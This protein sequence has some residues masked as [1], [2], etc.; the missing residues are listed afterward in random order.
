MPP[1]S[2]CWCRHHP[3]SIA[4]GLISLLLVSAILPVVLAEA[5]PE[6]CNLPLDTGNGGFPVLRYFY[7]SVTGE[8]VSFQYWSTGGNDNNF[9]TFA[10]CED[11]CMSSSGE[12][13]HSYVHAV[14]IY[15]D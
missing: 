9:E 5:A 10:D 6:E 14:P 3:S 8:C 12:L 15:A 4:T 7:S 1:S 2:N 13:Q 11:A